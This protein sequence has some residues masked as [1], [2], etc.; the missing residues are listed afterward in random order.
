MLLSAC[1]AHTPAALQRGAAGPTA[2]ERNSS[3]AVT[4][5]MYCVV[6]Q[7]PDDTS[8]EQTF[9]EFC[10]Y[11][12]KHAEV[13]PRGIM[14]ERLVDDG[15]FSSIGSDGSERTGTCIGEYLADYPRPGERNAQAL[16]HTVGALQGHELCTFTGLFLGG[17]A[18]PGEALVTEGWMY[19]ESETTYRGQATVRPA[20]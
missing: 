1:G 19:R 12:G 13:Y 17:S 5:D 9:E 16:P 11:E 14:R 15:E 2:T 6:R 7:L 8:T 20:L 10:L 4:V 3:S 18:R